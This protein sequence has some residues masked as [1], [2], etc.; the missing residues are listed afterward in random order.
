[1]RFVIGHASRRRIRINLN[2]S[3]SPINNILGQTQNL[4]HD[5]VDFAEWAEA[6]YSPATTLNRNPI[7]H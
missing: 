2:Q 4:M 3:E 6:G 7:P 5:V 1:M